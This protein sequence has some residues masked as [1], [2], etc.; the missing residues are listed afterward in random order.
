MET[1]TYGLEFVASRI[2]TD[3]I[4]DHRMTL[5]YLG[6]PVHNMT[7]MFGDNKSEVDSSTILQSKLNKRHNALSYNH[8]REAVAAK[9]INFSHIPGKLNPADILSKHWSYNHIW[10]TLQPLLFWKGDTLQLLHEEEK[11]EKSSST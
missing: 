3:H 10:C 7:Y 8:K 2:A 4:M 6:V 11:L 1:A 5:R 9:I